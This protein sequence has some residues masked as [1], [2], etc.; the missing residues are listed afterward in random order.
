[1]RHN[2]AM[3]GKYLLVIRL[4]ESILKGHIAPEIRVMDLL[5]L[6]LSNVL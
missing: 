5:C 6:N 4:D 3:I 1:M 2:A